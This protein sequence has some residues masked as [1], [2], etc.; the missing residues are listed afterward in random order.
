MNG[1]IGFDQKYNWNLFGRLNITC[2]Y[3][4]LTHISYCPESLDRKKCERSFCSCDTQQSFWS[5]TMQD[6]A[7]DYS[8]RHCSD[9]SFLYF[10]MTE[11]TTIYSWEG[12]WR[13][14][15]MTIIFYGRQILAVFPL[16]RLERI[17]FGF[18]WPLNHNIMPFSWNQKSKCFNPE[19][20]L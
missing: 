17:I 12:I 11:M 14:F 4:I 9:W 7:K 15:N 20:C 3:A 19:W 5:S 13:F 10:N 16:N 2:F 6:F 1:N 8:K 18:W